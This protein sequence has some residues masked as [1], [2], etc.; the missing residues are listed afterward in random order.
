MP[1]AGVPAPAAGRAGGGRAP[2]VPG[3]A[4]RRRRRGGRRGGGRSRARRAAGHPWRGPCR[5]RGRRRGRARP[6]PGEVPAKETCW[7]STW[8]QRPSA[9]RSRSASARC[10]SK[11][12]IAWATSRSTWAIDTREAN[13]P[14]C[15]STHAAASNGRVRVC[16][17]I[18]RAFHTGNRPA[19]TLAQVLGRRWTSSRACPRRLRPASCDMPR[20]VASSIT[21]NSATSGA[22]S[23]AMAMP[24][25]RPS[26]V[27]VA[28]VSSVAGCREAHS[29]ACSITS[30]WAV[31]RPDGRR[32]GC[33]APAPHVSPFPRSWSETLAARTDSPAPESPS[34]TALWK[35]ISRNSST[36]EAVAAT[37]LRGAIGRDRDPP[38]DVGTYVGHGRPG[39]HVLPTAPGAALVSSRSP[40]GSRLDRRRARGLVSASR[41]AARPTGLG[42]LDR[43][44]WCG[45]AG[46]RGVRGAAGRPSRRRRR[47]CPGPRSR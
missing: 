26:A 34:T 25:S 1:A 43:R 17:A 5:G 33:R 38:T 45:S 16:S 13:G 40:G 27:R 46:G 6:R 14:T 37:A 20:L 36:A 15:G 29:T 42:R 2:A 9:A 30:T 3:R 23:P 10:G 21:A 41:L 44:R 24:V 4:V 39:D 11:R 31:A 47:A 22:P 8:K 35:R 12:S 28:Q 32:A 19:S 7:W 18:R